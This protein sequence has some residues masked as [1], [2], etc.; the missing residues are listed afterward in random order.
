MTH[1]YGFARG[2]V[3]VY[4]VSCPLTGFEMASELGRRGIQTWAWV[5]D[6]SNVAFRTG[7]NQERFARSVLAGLGAICV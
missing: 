4:V 2:G 5:M 1:A 6:G 7:A 3:M